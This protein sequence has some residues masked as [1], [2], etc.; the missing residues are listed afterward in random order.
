VSASH[1]GTLSRNVAANPLELFVLQLAGE[2][3]HPSL[4]HPGHCLLDVS[5]AFDR[6]IWEEGS[7]NARASLRPS[8]AIALLARRVALLR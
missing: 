1:T 7:G 8:R 2:V 4:A 3:A 6:S 5:A